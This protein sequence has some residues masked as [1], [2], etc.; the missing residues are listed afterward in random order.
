MGCYCRQRAQ[1]QDAMSSCL[2]DSG[3][4]RQTSCT[5][6]A[7]KCPTDTLPSAQCI[8]SF[9]GAA[10]PLPL[11]TETH[12]DSDEHLAPSQPA[13]SP[14]LL[15]EAN[16]FTFDFKI[17]FDPS[18]TCCLDPLIPTTSLVLHSTGT[19]SEMNT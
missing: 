4:N 8:R 9:Q 15:S 12:Q 13:P 1:H 10:E 16:S 3:W 14:Q 6:F 18:M 7:S 5:D 17:T 2:E 11:F 19:S